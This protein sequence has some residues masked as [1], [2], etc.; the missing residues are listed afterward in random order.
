[1]ALTDNERIQEIF[2]VV[3]DKLAPVNRKWWYA[4]AIAVVA[5][6]PSYFLFKLGFVALAMS[7]YKAPQ[8]VYSIA[9]KEPLQLMDEQILQLSNNTY[10]GYFKIKNINFEWGVNSQAY[11]VEFR[12]NGGTV[13]SKTQATTFVLPSSEKIVVVPRFTADQRPDQIMV[14]LGETD[15]TRKPAIEVNLTQ[16]RVVLQNN[17]DG[18]VVSLGIRNQT[19]FTI[20]R[21]DMPV[22]VY[23]SRNEI[24][25]ANYTYI[26][27]L[28]SGETRTLQYSW[29]SRIE[30]AIR[31][32]IKP[33]V[34]VFAKGIF[35]NQQGISPF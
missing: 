4:L 19:P 25:A 23:N 13:L 10:L 9:V 11:T 17:P 18:L 8:I 26:N 27:D 2:L 33:E 29:P 22:L 5:V 12:T 24:V 14:T 21:V 32:E 16:E 15:F 1:M 28:A 35:I 31:A 7:N 34:N 30:G 3:G 20:K 6:V